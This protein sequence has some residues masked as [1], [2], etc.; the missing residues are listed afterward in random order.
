MRAPVPSMKLRSGGLAIS[1]LQPVRWLAAQRLV[2]GKNRG[3]TNDAK[4]CDVTRSN[5]QVNSNEDGR[6]ITAGIGG[7]SG[8]GRW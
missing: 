7:G 4:R 6:S 3:R 1:S 8:F 5:D 2:G